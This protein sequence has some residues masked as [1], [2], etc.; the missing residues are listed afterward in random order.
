[1]LLAISNTFLLKDEKTLLSSSKRLKDNH[2]IL[3]DSAS[4][5]TA[6][7]LLAAQQER[8]KKKGKGFIIVG[9]FLICFLRFSVSLC[10]SN[11]VFH[12]FVFSK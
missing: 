7:V 2:R 8:E 3:P 12:R 6:F 10:S 5:W 9:G 1:M 11:L 4:T